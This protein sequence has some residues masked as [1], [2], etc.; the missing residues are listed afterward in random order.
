MNLIMNS[1]RYFLSGFHYY[2]AIEKEIL[3]VLQCVVLKSP[4]MRICIYCFDEWSMRCTSTPRS[5]ARR[6]RGPSC[7]LPRSGYGTTRCIHRSISWDCRRPRPDTSS[8]GRVSHRYSLLLHHPLLL[9][10]QHCGCMSTQPADCK[11][12]Y[13]QPLPPHYYHHCYYRRGGF[14]SPE[15]GF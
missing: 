13:H 15:Q 8:S 9:A 4:T 7:P 5:A 14:L 1:K 3:S 10:L 6:A 12:C 11:Y 2:P